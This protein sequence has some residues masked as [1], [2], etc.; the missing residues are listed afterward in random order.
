MQLQQ[1]VTIDKVV[2]EVG[3]RSLRITMIKS[4]SKRR[5][6][7]VIV[8]KVEQGFWLRQRA[9]SSMREREGEGKDLMKKDRKRG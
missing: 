8:L 1:S 7:G 2:Q 5:A 9:E 4:Q 3:Q 6:S